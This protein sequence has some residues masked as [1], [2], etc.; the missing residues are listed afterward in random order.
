MAP[1]SSRRNRSNETRTKEI[2]R[3]MK[4]LPIGV[5]ITLIVIQVLVFA[6]SAQAKRRTVF[7]PNSGY[8][9]SLVHVGNIK[10]CKERRGKW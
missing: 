1:K 4:K 2:G 7:E 9:L 8:C 5:A 3:P 6:S 10:Y